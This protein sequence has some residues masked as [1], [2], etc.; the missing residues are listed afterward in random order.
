MLELELEKQTANLVDFDPKT[1]KFGGGKVPYA[2]LAVS[3]TLSADV[4]ANFSPTLKAMLF[5]EKG[6]KDLAG[7]TMPLRD[8][9]MVY[10]LDRDEEMT[11]ATVM[12]DVG[13]GDPMRFADVVVKDFQ[14]TPLPGGFVVVAFKVHCEPNEAQVG[15]LYMMQEQPITI[16]LEPMELPKMQDAA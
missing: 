16:T 8:P 6:P 14:L 13:I 1:K 9:H 15:K 2:V 11:G 7:D 4:L 12:I 10:P 5:D 3:C